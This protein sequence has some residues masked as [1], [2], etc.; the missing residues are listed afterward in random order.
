MASAPHKRCSRVLPPPSAQGTA[1]VPTLTLTKLTPPSFA[2]MKPLKG[3]RSDI[4]A[5]APRC[6]VGQGP[7][8]HCYG[9]HLGEMQPEAAE[10]SGAGSRGQGHSSPRGVS[11]VS[12]WL[13]PEDKHSPHQH[14]FT[15]VQL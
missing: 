5:P 6:C 2:V 9:L 14:S 1:Q 7:S 13:Y 12:S 15:R 4:S 11:G 10:A 3:T 8:L